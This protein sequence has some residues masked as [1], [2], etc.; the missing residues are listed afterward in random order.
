MLEISWLL[1]TLVALIISGYKLIADGFSEAV[2]YIIVMGVSFSMYLIRRKQ[3]V[4]M[5]KEA[6][7]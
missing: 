2:F 6:G 1:L 7:M 5:N 4:R 3:R